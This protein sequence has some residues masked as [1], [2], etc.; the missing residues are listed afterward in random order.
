MWIE[1][2]RRY[3][4]INGTEHKKDDVH[5]LD[6]KAAAVALRDGMGVEVEAPSD[7]PSKPPKAKAKAKAKE[8]K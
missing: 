3:L 1:F 8:R 5:E 4:D 6:A 7:E 2:S